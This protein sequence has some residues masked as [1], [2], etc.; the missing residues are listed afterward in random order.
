MNG[1]LFSAGARQ[2]RFVKDRGL[3]TWDSCVSAILYG[4]EPGEAQR[5]FEAWCQTKPEGDA[6][7][8]INI[9]RITAVQLVDQLLTESGGTAINWPEIARRLLD[10]IMATAVDASE[11]GLWADVNQLVPPMAHCGDFQ[12]FQL[13]M[14][15]EIRSGLNWSLDKQCVFLVTAMSPAPPP[16]DPNKEFDEKETP[17]DDGTEEGQEANDD[18]DGFVATLPEMREKEAAGLVEARNAVVA[19]WLWRAFLA[20]TPAAANEISVGQC[21]TIFSAEGGSTASDADIDPGS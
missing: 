14:P 8:E 6:E 11:Q 16:P 20:T 4:S 1:Y 9:K 12:S 18:L 21:C 5:Q 13:A 3:L 15:D 10:P 19:G 17:P 7:A 2:T